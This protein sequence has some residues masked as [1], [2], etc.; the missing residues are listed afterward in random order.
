MSEVTQEQVVSA[1]QEQHSNSLEELENTLSELGHSQSK[2]LLLAAMRY[3]LQDEEFTE[4]VM[5]QA[6]SACKR[7]I[8]VNVAMGVELTVE[9]MVQNLKEQSNESK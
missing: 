8:D 2:R 9:N 1:L 4:E 3:P 5:R 6:F 7:L